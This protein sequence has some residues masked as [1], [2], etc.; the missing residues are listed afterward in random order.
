MSEVHFRFYEELNDFLPVER[1]RRE[2]P[3]AG[4]PRNS[5]KDMIE[6][7]GVPHTEIDLIL[8][9]GETV[10]FSY[11]VRPGDRISVYPEFES[12]DIQAVNRLRPEPLRRTRFVLDTHLG[13]LARYL[14]LLGF[15]ALYSNAYKDEEL[16]AISSRGDKRILLT[17]DRGLLKRS[18]V[19]HGYYVRETR[20]LE[21]AREVVRRFDLRRL[22]RAFGRCI[23]CNG[24]LIRTDCE[25]VADRLPPR[26]AAGFDEFSVCR[27][28]SRVYW[29]GSHYDRLRRIVDELTGKP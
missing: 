17:R 8:V 10:D 12:F 16:A 23:Q 28:C 7:L 19:T 26:I 5:V 21:Q 6:S 14:R 22:V 18:E 9:N 4:R 15:D 11:L 27:D 20:P 25:E 24:E 2:F 1:R 3:V 29:K 13:K